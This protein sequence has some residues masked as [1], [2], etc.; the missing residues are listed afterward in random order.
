MEKTKI[1][2]ELERRGLQ[3][4]GEITMQEALEIP[5]FSKGSVQY[6]AHYIDW[7]KKYEKENTYLYFALRKAPEGAKLGDAGTECKDIL[8]VVDNENK[9]EKIHHILE[10]GWHI[11]AREDV[12]YLEVGEDCRIELC[13]HICGCNSETGYS[14]DETWDNGRNAFD[15]V[16]GVKEGLGFLPETCEPVVVSRPLYRSQAYVTHDTVRNIEITEIGTDYY[17]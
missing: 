12:T 17:N 10:T 3:F 4:R 8:I 9:D 16:A 15:A 7:N 6:Y 13:S 1:V 2:K 14:F 11:P 5:G